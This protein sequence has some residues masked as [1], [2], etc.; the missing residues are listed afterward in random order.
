MR[1]AEDPARDVLDMADGEN[2]LPVLAG[3]VG[4]GAVDQ[5]LRP[6]LAAACSARP[7]RPRS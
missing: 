2:R 1:T 7:P 5:R 6:E 4:Q 3:A